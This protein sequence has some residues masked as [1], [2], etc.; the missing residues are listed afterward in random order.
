DQRR[1]RLGEALVDPLVAAAET[2]VIFG[3]VDPVVEERPER[4]VGIAVI[5]FVDVLLLEVDRRGGDAVLAMQ[6]DLAGEFL[7]LLAR[8]AEPDAAI[9]PERGG[10]GDRKAALRA[11]TARLRRRDTVGDDDQAAHLTEVQGR[12]R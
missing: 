6:V 10:E 12:E 1:D 2:A 8:P 3:E 11:G 7:G 4:P 5:I 9:L